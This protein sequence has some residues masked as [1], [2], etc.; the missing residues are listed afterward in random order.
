MNY[1]GTQRDYDAIEKEEMLKL[2][3]RNAAAAAANRKRDE[4]MVSKR[5]A[6]VNESIDDMPDNCMMRALP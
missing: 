3:K 1:V 4:A 2:R 5:T 6:D